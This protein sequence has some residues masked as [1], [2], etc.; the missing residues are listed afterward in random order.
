MASAFFYGTLMHP[1]VLQRVIGHNGSSLELCPALLLNY[2]RHKVKRAEYPG[3]VPYEQ[4]RILIGHDLP[5]E[6]RSVRGTL[7]LGLSQKDLALLDVFEGDDYDRQKVDVHPL[8][9]FVK[10]S[11]YPFDDKTLIPSKPPILPPTLAPPF[12]TDTYVYNMFAR[13]DPDIWSFEDFVK[14]NAWKWYREQLPDDDVRWTEL[15]EET[16]SS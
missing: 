9:T 16:L 5:L 3:M 8:S 7:F 15:D 14:K 11:E 12:R 6:D 2:T 10:L 4:S 13:L 1:K